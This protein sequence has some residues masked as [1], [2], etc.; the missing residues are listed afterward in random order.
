MVQY[1]EKKRTIAIV[2]ASFRIVNVRAKFSQLI[3]CNMLAAEVNVCVMQILKIRAYTT[4]A[5]PI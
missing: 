1:N 5:T 2:P 3:C 4:I